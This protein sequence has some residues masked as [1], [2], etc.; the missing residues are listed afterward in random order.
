MDKLSK[1]EVA[2]LFE[3]F[4]CDVEQWTYFVKWLEKHG[5]KVEELGMSE[6]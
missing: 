1:E 4:L 5:Y 6:E 2:K 3:S